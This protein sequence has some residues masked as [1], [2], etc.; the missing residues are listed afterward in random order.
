MKAPEGPDNEQASSA[1]PPPTEARQ[2]APWECFFRSI[3]DSLRWR[4]VHPMPAAED[5]GDA[6]V[7]AMQRARRLC[8]LHARYELG[9]S[10]FESIRI[11]VRL[12]EVFAAWTRSH[13][14]RLAELGPALERLERVARNAASVTSELSFVHQLMDVA[15][16]TE[17]QL[18]E[19]EFALE[20][21]RRSEAAQGIA[22]AS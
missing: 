15:D 2:L 8:W 19:M 14:P 3:S 4:R 6:M 7:R 17:L 11:S 5:H 22:R 18:V 13:D 21:L 1:G 12:S 20:A 10:M 16:S 9:W